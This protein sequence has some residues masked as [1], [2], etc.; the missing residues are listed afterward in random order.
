MGCLKYQPRNNFDTLCHV[1]K[2]GEVL[3]HKYIVLK[4]LPR[5]F[6]FNEFGSC[7]ACFFNWENL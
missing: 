1:E 6:W 3:R 7:W 2:A 5:H 4:V